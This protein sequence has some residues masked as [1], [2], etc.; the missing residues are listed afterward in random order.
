LG[1]HVLLTDLPSITKSILT[2]N[3][4]QNSN[5][6]VYSDKTTQGPWYGAKKIG[7][8]GGTAACMS[9]DWTEPLEIHEN[10]P[11]H[12]NYIF[13]T[14]TVWLTDLLVPFVNT[15]C[16]ILIEGIHRPV[17]YL[18]FKDRHSGL[19]ETFTQVQKLVDKFEAKGCTVTKIPFDCEETSKNHVYCITAKY[20]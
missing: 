6:D 14:D 3:I 12:T 5:G 15:V 7:I 1:G 20:I 16:N 8:N 4:V 11:L 18:A 19:T 13:A 10:N 17:C 2:T 9:L